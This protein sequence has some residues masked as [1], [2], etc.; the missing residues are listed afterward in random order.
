MAKFNGVNIDDILSAGGGSSKPSGSSGKKRKKYPAAYKEKPISTVAKPDMKQEKFVSPYQQYMMSLPGFASLAGVKE[1]TN[2]IKTG[3]EN[4]NAPA[5]KAMKSAM[6]ANAGIVSRGARASADGSGTAIASM[7]GLDPRRSSE[8]LVSPQSWAKASPEVKAKSIQD[9]DKSIKFVSKTP[10]ASPP[11]DDNPD[12]Y[13]YADPVINIKGIKINSPLNGLR[14]LSALD[15]AALGASKANR[16]YG[17]SKETDEAGAKQVSGWINSPNNLVGDAAK[18]GAVAGVPLKTIPSAIMGIAQVVGDTLTHPKDISNNLSDMNNQSDRLNR[19]RSISE[20]FRKGWNLENGYDTSEMLNDYGWNRKQWTE[21]RKSV[22]SGR[23][24]TPNSSVDTASMFPVTSVAPKSNRSDKILRAVVNTEG[25]IVASPINYLGLGAGAESKAGVS[26]LAS[27]LGSNGTNTSLNAAREAL[28]ALD[29]SAIDAAPELVGTAARTAKKTAGQNLLKMFSGEAGATPEG[30]EKLANLV[31]T[32]YGEEGASVVEKLLSAAER[33]RNPE[34]ISQTLERTVSAPERLARELEIAGKKYGVENLADLTPEQLAMNKN[35]QKAAAQV[36]R[37][38]QTDF[39]SLALEVPG[40][41]IRTDAPGVSRP[42][43]ELLDDLRNWAPSEF[44]GKDVKTPAEISRYI[45]PRN[46]SAEARDIADMP[47]TSEIMRQQGTRNA[48]MRRLAQ[49]TAREEVQKVADEVT[50]RG[51]ATAMPRPGL[52]T[53]I[54][55]EAARPAAQYTRER[56]L[57]QLDQGILTSDDIARMEMY[58]MIPTASDSSADAVID[59]GNSELNRVL[60]R[61]TQTPDPAM[62]D[63]SDE[64]GRLN[65]QMER[66]RAL[67]INDIASQGEIPRRNQFETGFGGYL[68][69]SEALDAYNTGVPYQPHIGQARVNPTEPHWSESVI[70]SLKQTAPSE[71]QAR[72]TALVEDALKNGTPPTREMFDLD[73]FG[74]SDFEDALKSYV[75][76]NPDSGV[77]VRSALQDEL[78]RLDPSTIPHPRYQDPAWSDKIGEMQYTGGKLTDWAHFV[79][80]ENGEMLDLL[81]QPNP[82][83]YLDGKT[84]IYRMF[85]PQKGAPFDPNAALPDSTGRYGRYSSTGKIPSN[86][87][88]RT[89]GMVN[90]SAVHEPFY[91]VNAPRTLQM[92]ADNPTESATNWFTKNVGDAPDEQEMRRMLSQYGYAE[93]AAD[94]EYLGDGTFKIV[95]KHNPATIEYVNPMSEQVLQTTQGSQGIKIDLLKDMNTSFDDSAMGKGSGK[96]ADVVRSLMGRA[97]KDVIDNNPA[98]M[99]IT[100]EPANEKVARMYAMLGFQEAPT[101]SIDGRGIQQY[102]RDGVQMYTAGLGSMAGIEKDENGKIKFDPKKAALGMAAGYAGGALWNRYAPEAGNSVLQDIRSVAMGT[103]AVDPTINNLLKRSSYELGNPEHQVAQAAANNGMLSNLL[104]NPK[105]AK[106]GEYDYQSLIDAVRQSDEGAKVIA[107]YGDEEG[108]KVIE[109]AVLSLRNQSEGMLNE[110]IAKNIP[111]NARDFYQPTM[112]PETSWTRPK[113]SQGGMA[114]LLGQSGYEAK[115]GRELTPAERLAQVAS[116]DYGFDTVGATKNAAE[117]NAI[118]QYRSGEEIKNALIGAQQNKSFP[119][120]WARLN[121]EVNGVAAPIATETDPLK[122]LERSLTDRRVLGANE[123]YLFSL[124]DKIGTRLQKTAEGRWV[125]PDGVT[126]VPDTNLLTNQTGDYGWYMPNESVRNTIQNYADTGGIKQATTNPVARGMERLA[127]QYTPLMYIMRP[128]AQVKNAA[129]NAYRM[130]QE[131]EMNPSAL[132]R[133][134]S[135]IAKMTEAANSGVPLEDIQGTV[136]I[137]GEDYPIARLLKEFEESGVI[138]PRDMNPRAQFDPTNGSSF[139]DKIPG[140]AGWKEGMQRASSYVEG[141]PRSAIAI[142][143]MDRGMNPT[144][145]R[146][147][148]DKVLYNYDVQAMSPAEQELRKFMPFFTWQRNNIPAQAEYYAKHPGRV[149]MPLNFATSISEQQ[150]RDASGNPVGT[151]RD[152]GIKDIYQGAPNYLSDTIPMVSGKNAHDTMMPDSSIMQILQNSESIFQGGRQLAET[153]GKFGGSRVKEGLID[154]AMQQVAPNYKQAMQL[155]SG[156]DQYGRT[157]E[158]VDQMFPN[159]PMLQSYISAQKRSVKPSMQGGDVDAVKNFIGNQ[160]GISSYPFN[161]QAQEYRRQMDAGTN[162][163]NIE[164]IA[165]NMGTPFDAPDTESMKQAFKSSDQSRIKELLGTYTGDRNTFVDDEKV[166]HAFSN[167][168]QYMDGKKQASA[169]QLTDTQQDELKRKSPEAYRWWVK[170]GGVSSGGITFK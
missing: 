126:P 77:S 152:V 143:G 69:Y 96:P 70:R 45:N 107:K 120:M 14:L 141:V 42:I 12:M 11:R 155:A 156:F 53:E 82:E 106:V 51:A 44:L 59:T 145:A 66:S 86:M 21:P 24:G 34:T 67:R 4:P 43:A 142:N 103:D 116:G 168:K 104:D 1:N 112:N 137:A 39:G 135:V 150:S 79:R 134:T 113:G 170:R 63:E 75:K 125:M 91:P 159:I 65:S 132:A 41:K 8:P 127:R 167:Y 162:L 13:N 60:Q 7:L 15:Q 144:A 92:L 108:Q 122:T 33:M 121:N 98:T 16:K 146:D 83:Q 131:G 32:H 5:V 153:G 89:E 119:S 164:Q 18:V 3:V 87:L 55:D 78:G 165:G 85:D 101:A 73:R 111:Y 128:A 118:G 147:L 9:I 117:S 109:N 74:Y 2:T 57:Q 72:Q 23:G 46:W 133:S 95:G 20:G 31:D 48:A 22:V 158:G 56:A 62:F 68:D 157:L 47:I 19:V 161:P 17:W 90:D 76:A 148:A 37:R 138:S 50:P 6:S 123:D 163:K 10:M 28:T 166:N 38:A 25:N 88:Q 99:P 35:A 84:P 52:S 139:W 81:D 100:T 115:L 30:V 27:E 64:F 124:G 54:V 26:R 169:I 102:P 80:G 49:A 40:T 94:A 160:M 61:E 71:T 149:M 97:G 29:T 114:N 129:G 58:G 36:A 110:D 151:P 140:V 136:K 93:G 105:M 154:S 130:L